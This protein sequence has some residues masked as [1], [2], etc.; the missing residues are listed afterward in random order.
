[1]SM[2]KKSFQQVVLKKLEVH[3]KKKYNIPRTLLKKKKKLKK[4]DRLK[5][6][7]DNF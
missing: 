5:V 3:R 6:K 2:K 7:L 1:M 4:H